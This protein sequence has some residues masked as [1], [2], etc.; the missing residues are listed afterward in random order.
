MVPICY[1][2]YAL[3]LTSREILSCA[4]SGVLVSTIPSSPNFYYN[5]ALITSVCEI[6]ALMEKHNIH[7]LK[8]V[9]NMTIDTYDE[10][11]LFF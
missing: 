5:T 11:F 2:I 8:S 3:T 6:R 1:M 9:L 10:K 4:V 7:P